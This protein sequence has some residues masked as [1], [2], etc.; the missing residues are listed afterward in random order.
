MLANDSLAESTSMDTNA[1]SSIQSPSD[2]G[3]ESSLA[4]TLSLY[5]VPV[6]YLALGAFV[7]AKKLV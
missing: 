5:W 1:T 3:V 6:V 7:V 4:S 2:S